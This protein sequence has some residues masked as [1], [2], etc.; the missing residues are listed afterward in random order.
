MSSPKS[1]TN[2]PLLSTTTTTTTTAPNT[3]ASLLAVA[4]MAFGL[5]CLLAPR[6]TSALLLLDPIAPQAALVTRLY[7]GAVVA[8]GSLLW[9]VNAARARGDV[10]DDRLLKHVVAVNIAA[11]AVDVASCAVGWAGGAVTG[12]VAGVLGGGCAALEVLGMVAYRSI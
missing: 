11:D 1:T 3:P 9:L 12:V 10:G 2:T 4:K 5:S 8:L 6:L 7:G